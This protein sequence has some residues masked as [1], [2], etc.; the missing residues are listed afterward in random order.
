VT[1]PR[2]KAESPVKRGDP[3]DLVDRDAE[4]LPRMLQCLFG[5]IFFFGLNIL[6][7]SQDCRTLPLILFDDG[8][9]L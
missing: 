3:I 5:E 9:D 7:D 6:K 1:P 2:L 4:P 8:I